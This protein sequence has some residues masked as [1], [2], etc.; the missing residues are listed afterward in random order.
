ME[1]SH[2]KKGHIDLSIGIIYN[3]YTALKISVHFGNMMRSLNSK[4]KKKHT[5]LQDLKRTYFYKYL[6]ASASHHCCPYSEGKCLLLQILI[7]YLPTLDFLS[8]S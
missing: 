1:Q 8:L 3:G 4:L 7:S 2:G 5:A 6:K